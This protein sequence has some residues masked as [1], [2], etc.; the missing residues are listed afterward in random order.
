MQLSIDEVVE[1]IL[2]KNNIPPDEYVRVP[3]A[4]HLGWTN[5]YFIELIVK[6]ETGPK[7]TSVERCGS[8]AFYKAIAKLVTP[9]TGKLH[10]GG[11]SYKNKL[12]SLAQIKTCPRCKNTKYYAEFGIASNKAYGRANYCKDCMSVRNK[13][14]YDNNKDRYHKSYIEE[15]LSEY[16]ARN[17]KRRAT[18]INA[19]PSWANLSLIKRIYENAEGMHVDHIIP[20]QGELVCGLHVEN[21]L[22]YLTPEENSRK[23]NKL[24]EE[25]TTGNFS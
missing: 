23:G 6:Y 10:G 25:F 18:K 13:N 4:D 22:Q 3:R 11:E 21:N 9:I 8:P 24:L 14:F 16:R 19:T 12:F 2:T 1:L 20:L 7:I 5:K 15:H 17:A